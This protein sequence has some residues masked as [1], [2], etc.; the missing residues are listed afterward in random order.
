[1]VN[2]GEE[3][4]EEPS[5]VSESATRGLNKEEKQRWEKK[6]VVKEAGERGMS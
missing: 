5:E 2:G 3:L 6:E 4:E 1:M